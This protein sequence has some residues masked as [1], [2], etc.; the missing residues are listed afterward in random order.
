MKLHPWEK[1]VIG[2]KE[3]FLLR[4]LLEAGSRL[5]A[6]AVLAAAALL[7]IDRAL[8]LTA[9]ARGALLAISA[10][11]LS[12]AVGRSASV[13]RRFDWGRFFTELAVELPPLRHHIRAAWELRNEAPEG[14]SAELIEAH[15]RQTSVLVMSL[16]EQAVFPWKPSS[17]VRKCALGALLAAS[18][19]PF[20]TADAWRRVFIPWSEVPL[21][22]VLEMMPGDL[23]AD[24]GSSVELRARWRTAAGVTGGEDLR[25]ELRESGPWKVREWDKMMRDGGSWTI[26]ELK[27]P[28]EYRARLRDRTTRTFRLI[29][30]PAPE[31]T[32]V[33]ARIVTLAGRAEQAL[34]PEVPLAALRGSWVSVSGK[35]NGPMAKAA[36]KLSYQTAELPLNTLPSGELQAG[37]QAVEDG[38]FHFLLET[39]D[40]RRDDSP[41]SYSLKVV[42]DK[43]PEIEILSPLGSLQASPRDVLSVAYSARDDAGLR[44]TS[45]L[46]RAPGVTEVRR[47]LEVF[48]DRRKEHIGD[49]SWD[50]SGLPL[51]VAL[52]LRLKAEDS[53]RVPQTAL[54]APLM[55]ELVDFE[56]AHAAMERLWVKSLKSL[57]ELAAREEA[58]EGQLAQGG[59]E[60]LEDLLSSL[61]EDW[62]RTAGELSELSQSMEKDVYANPGIERQTRA[63]ASE[64]SA[65]GQKPLSA[66]NA[67]ARAGRWEE[68]RQRHGKLSR[69][70]RKAERL[71]REQMELQAYQDFHSQTARLSQAGAEIE[72]ALDKMASAKPG[73][74]PSPEDSARL[75][76]AL[77]R[78]QRQMSELARAVASLPPPS[79]NAQ[80]KSRKT[81]TVPM[82]EAQEVADMLAKAI[83]EGDY[84][85]AAKLANALSERLAAVQKSLGEAARAAASPQESPDSA[86]LE[87]AKNLW[88]ET[89]ADQARDA[90]LTQALEQ[91]KL[92]DL[93][94]E[95]KKL[96]AS[97]A[98]EQAA[99]ISSAAVAGP[100]GF[101]AEALSDMRRVHQELTSRRL[102]DSLGLLKTISARLRGSWEP[103]ALAEDRIR[104]SLESFPQTPAQGKPD[105][106][107]QAAAKSQSRTRK[108]AGDL[109]TALEAI[110]Q[111]VATLPPG[112]LERLESARTQQ[113]MAEEALSRGETA[114]A[115]KHQEEALTLLESGMGDMSQAVSGQQGVEQGMG[116]PFG[117]QPGSVRSM[118]GSG[119]M[120]MQTGPVPVPSAK[121][122]RPPFE[123]REELERSLREKRPAAYDRVIKEYFKRVAQ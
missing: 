1:R 110:S 16:P 82:G 33:T 101:P 43:P 116:E 55:V 80:E 38:N 26:A 19:F 109:Q 18:T 37:F 69:E 90:E 75:A 78:L 40:G 45:L 17:L 49:F 102:R 107:S 5:I 58:L 123:L 99:L 81:V 117:R 115:L 86:R 32:D 2:W 13:L 121:D 28:L 47:P 96:L 60:G 112:T 6:V 44:G 51:G 118:S 42:A 89:L 120:G 122:Y 46:I 36:L 70:L 111:D 119:S 88:E 27:A 68:A 15:C 71:M 61:P 105:A 74:K 95:Q 83:A 53:A 76:G 98:A 23:A 3:Q 67:E 114:S 8:I 50:L 92:G 113:G 30:R 56:S 12:A 94:E 106:Q 34:V 14:V 31:L 11:G 104:S 57:G 85:F 39:P 29:P 73:S 62:R 52:E 103:F 22:S 84:A 59:V 66:A 64:L 91:Q 7:W 25:L 77:D 24:W 21:E 87:A 41:L 35:P 100:R 65:L 97:L 63:L 48:A 79:G 54:S 10:V 93:L 72:S 108:K 20:F 4:D 9:V